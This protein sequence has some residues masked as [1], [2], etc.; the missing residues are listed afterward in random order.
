M[1]AHTVIT[2]D[3]PLPHPEAAWNGRTRQLRSCPLFRN[4]GVAQVRAILRGTGRRHVDRGG[5]YFRQG[6][7]AAEAY[8]LVRG[9][10]KLVRAGSD[11]RR[12]ILNFISPMELFG[13]EAALGGTGHVV[14]A[15]AT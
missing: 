11:K 3:W 2:G 1:A 15:Q 14:S 9:R 6:D 13:Y 8:V 10:V 5:F 4:V 12:G 7:R